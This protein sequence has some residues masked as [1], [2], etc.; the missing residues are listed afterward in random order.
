[1]VDLPIIMQLVILEAYGEA[2][3]RSSD[4]LFCLNLALSRHNFKERCPTG[5]D[6]LTAQDETD[7]E[8]VEADGG[9]GIGQVRTT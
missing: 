3:K 4:K 2:Q 5:D 1:M 6:P 7:C 9:F 8:G